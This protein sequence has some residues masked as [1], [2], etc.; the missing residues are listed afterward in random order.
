[1]QPERVALR[2]FGVYLEARKRATVELPA[3]DANLQLLDWWYNEKANGNTYTFEERFEHSNNNEVV[4]AIHNDERVQETQKRYRTMEEANALSPLTSIEEPAYMDN[5]D[6][7]S[8]IVA[9]QTLEHTTSTTLD[10]ATATALNDSG[11][12][13]IHLFI[14]AKPEEINDQGMGWLQC[15]Q[16]NSRGC[17]RG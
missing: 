13:D 4:S 3:P 11:Q 14:A 17:P 12:Y 1:V 15:N 9:Q 8:V 2:A 6:D 5:K 7:T 16:G 10:V